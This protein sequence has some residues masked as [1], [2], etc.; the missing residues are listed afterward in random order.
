MP[1]KMPVTLSD[2]EFERMMGEFQSAGQWMLEQL[3]LKRATPSATT[4]R[5][6]IAN[7]L[8]QHSEIGAPTFVKSGGPP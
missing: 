5:Q 8:E 4:A 7:C 1:D 6:L 3:A 2:D